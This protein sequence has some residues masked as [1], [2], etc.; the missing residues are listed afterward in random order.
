MKKAKICLCPIGVLALDENGKLI[1]QRLFPKD[2]GVIAQKMASSEDADRLSEE[3][4]SKGY[5]LEKGQC[6]F[7]KFAFQ[8]GWA[9][10]S[11]ELNKILTAIAAAQT[12]TK[13]R[14]PKSD[15]L[16]MAVI[17]IVDQ[18]DKDLNSYSERLR[19]WYG[20]H[21]PE[22][23]KAVTSNKALSQIIARYGSRENIKEA[24]LV[25]LARQ[26]A[27]MPLSDED[28]KVVQAFAAGLSELFI[29][30]EQVSKYIE[31]LIQTVAPN[32]NAIA[33][34]LL[35]ARLLAQA[36]GLEKL[37]RL[38]AST[39]QLLGAEKAL[40]RHLKENAKVPKYGL[41][42]GHHAVQSAPAEFKGKIARL[43]AAK[44]SLASRID[45]F[46]GQDRGAEMKKDLDEQ[47]KKILG[48]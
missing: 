17:G 41:L 43:I 3:L 45:F 26:S 30:K 15:R 24:K 48:K 31:E 44:L 29:V 23:V 27:G 10:D 37:S 34:P 4:G 2:P 22:G 39:V 28:V 9:K 5:E 35:T 46:S 6:D 40:F 11:Q 36:G 14:K 21:F 42:F 33:G 25:E 13:L 12:K 19:E 32:C 18:M 16:V 8:L 20:L 7:R 38:P 47:I 1:S